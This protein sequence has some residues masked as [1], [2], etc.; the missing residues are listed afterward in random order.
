MSVA[1]ACQISKL[2]KSA[3]PL[4]GLRILITRPKAQSGELCALLEGLGARTCALPTL[5]IEEP[6]DHGHL[7]FLLERL[8]QFDW[9]VF[10]SA[11]GV[12]AFCT[13]AQE[14]RVP[15]DRYAGRI[16]CIGP[17]TAQ[18]LKV[19]W[20]E[21]DVIPQEF[22]SDAIPDI[23][24]EVRGKKILLARADKAR[25]DLTQQ[26][27]RRGAAVADV[28]AYRSVPLTEEKAEQAVKI[29]QDFGVP[30]LVTFTSPLTVRGFQSV[31]ASFGKVNAFGDIP[32][33]SI[34][35]I[36]ARAVR[37]AGGNC[38]G[39]ASTY[40]CAGLVQEICRLVEEGSLSLSPCTSFQ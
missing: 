12:R 8:E 20:R 15:F 22:I 34:G 23:L 28:V 3:L 2:S 14:S 38:I 9:I 4:S 36:T 26:L 24:G 32:S 29:L 7:R 21:A 33:V 16:A 6:A 17:A 25:R 13:M 19:L 10:T 30:D 27:V 37:A 35:P 18:V 11:N 1:M 5:A 31:L 40:T 39:M